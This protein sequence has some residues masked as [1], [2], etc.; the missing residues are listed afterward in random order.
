MLTLLSIAVYFFSIPIVEKTKKS[1]IF[2]YSLLVMAVT[3]FLFS[4]NDNLIIFLTL[5]VILTI[6][7]TFRITSFGLIIKDASRKN[8]LSENVQTQLDELQGIVNSIQPDEKSDKNVQRKRPKGFDEDDEAI[9]GQQ[10]LAQEIRQD[11]AQL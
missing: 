8:R 3:Y 9:Q 6:V 11:D 2:S 10:G 1:V 7:T 5:A 4:L